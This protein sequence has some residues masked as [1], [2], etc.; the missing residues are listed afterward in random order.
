MKTNIRRRWR[1]SASIL[2]CYRAKLATR[3]SLPIAASYISRA[4]PTRFTDHDQAISPLAAVGGGGRERSER[5]VGGLTPHPARRK[6]R[7]RHLLLATGRRV[8]DSG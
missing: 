1:R 7:L 2:A 5:R 6:T 8:T 4:D 3:R